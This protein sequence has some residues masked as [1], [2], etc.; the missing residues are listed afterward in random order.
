MNARFPALF[1][2][3]FRAHFRALVAGLTLLALP[4]AAETAKGPNLDPQALSR[5]G[6]VA[7]LYLAQDLYLQG[8][9]TRD[10]L[11]LIQS[12]RMMRRVALIPAPD[13]LPKTT[14]KRPAAD[15]PAPLPFPL[16]D[17][18]L[19]TAAILARG[20][21][22]LASLIDDTQSAQPVPLG[23]VRQ[24]TSALAP[25]GTD[26]WTLSFF[27]GVTAELAVLGNGQST[28]SI[29][30]TDENGQSPCMVLAGAD[31]LYCR[32]TPAA[33]GSFTVTVSNPGAAVEAYR[34]I[35]N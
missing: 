7:R 25:G 31:R 29:T 3:H 6:P 33:N 32:F 23:G 13:R 22:T 24:S 18:T 27:G 34:L 28:L 16:P 14:G 15:A 35:T 5:P 19:K 2:A 8:L 26:A 11:A 4:A 20:D 17:A 30:V 9:A 10:A 12:A 1:R 21:D